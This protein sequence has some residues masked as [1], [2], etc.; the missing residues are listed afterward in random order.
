MDSGA[1]PPGLK[2]ALAFPLI[3]GLYAR[4][5]RRFSLGASI[6][7]SKI[8][9][10]PAPMPARWPGRSSSPRWRFLISLDD[11]ASPKVPG[12]TTTLS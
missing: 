5:A 6:T 1:F 3:E 10:P 2:D 4:D 8:S 11:S 7:E 12:S 9:K